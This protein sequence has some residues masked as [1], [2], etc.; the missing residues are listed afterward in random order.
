MARV[1]DSVG[2]DIFWLAE[3]Y[4]WWRKHGMEA[5]SSTVMTAVIARETKN[6]IIG[7][8]II[9]PYTRHPVQIA[10]EARVLQEA[11]GS[12]RFLL[13]LGASKIFMKEIGEGESGKEAS[14]AVVMRESLEIIRAML[15]G[16]EVAYQGKAF[17]AFAP[18]LKREAH[19]P[20]GSVP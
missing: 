20:R 13:G 12:G 6:I 14:P 4:P 15:N 9:S 19:S 16:E 1:C 11:A 18:A 2:F 17:S 8:G 7:W 10:M 5:R 3:A